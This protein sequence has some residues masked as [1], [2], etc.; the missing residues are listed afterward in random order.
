MKETNLSSEQG[1]ARIYRVYTLNKD[2]VHIVE[3]AE[4]PLLG[5]YLS[6]KKYGSPDYC[7]SATRHH[8]LAKLLTGNMPN[9]VYFDSTEAAVAEGFTPCSNCWIKG[10]KALG[11]WH[12]YLEACRTLGVNPGSTPKVIIKLVN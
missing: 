7:P 3:Q 6:M 10:E 9:L 4:K 2:G 11:R 5:G 12:E 8:R 1:P